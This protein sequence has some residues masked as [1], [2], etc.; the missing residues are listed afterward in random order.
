MKRKKLNRAV[1]CPQCHAVAPPLPQEEV[2][3]IPNAQ[4][5]IPR[6][7]RVFCGIRAC[8]AMFYIVARDTDATQ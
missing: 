4:P 1:V 8:R 7:F 5:P 3:A 2:K 6:R